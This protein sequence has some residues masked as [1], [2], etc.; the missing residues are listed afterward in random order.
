M[1]SLLDGTF[2]P[3]PAGER[4]SRTGRIKFG[5]ESNGGFKN[6]TVTNCVF[7][8]CQGLTLESVDGGLLEDL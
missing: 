8:G 5:T 6:V 1:A 4:I 7:D 3:L 2:K